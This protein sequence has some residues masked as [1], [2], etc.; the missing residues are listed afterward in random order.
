MHVSWVKFGPLPLGRDYKK[1][2]YLYLPKPLKNMSGC[3]L[4][5]ISCIKLIN[6]QAR[7]CTKFNSTL[8]ANIFFKTFEK[9]NVWLQSLVHRYCT[10]VLYWGTVLGTGVLYWG[11][12]T[13]LGY[14]TGVLYWGTVLGY[15]TRHWG[16]VLG[17]RY[18]TGVLYWGTGTVL[19]YRY[20]T[21]VPVLYWGT[22]LGYCTGVLYWGTGTVLGYCTRHWGTGT[23]VLYWGT[24]L[25]YCTGVLYW[26]TVLGTGVLY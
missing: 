14:C 22:V 17:Y 4:R 18:C 19:V 13:V 21:G 10:G 26:G 9:H 2:I 6:Y 5:L 1:I 11:T 3:N 25:G 20:C 24:V 16:T 15:C 12:G 7:Q 23:G 8:A